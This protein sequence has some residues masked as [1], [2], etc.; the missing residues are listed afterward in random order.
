MEKQHSLCTSLKVEN[1]DCDVEAAFP[2]EG[3]FSTAPVAQNEFSSSSAISNQT[4]ELVEEGCSA[5]LLGKN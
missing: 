2:H 4:P 1:Q 5:L 3:M